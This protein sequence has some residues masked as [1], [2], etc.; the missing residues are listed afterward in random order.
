MKAVIS[1]AIWFTLALYLCTQNRLS[2]QNWDNIP[3]GSHCLLTAFFLFPQHHLVYSYRGNPL[4]GGLGGLNT[5]CFLNALAIVD[6][7][8]W[9]LSWMA[10]EPPPASSAEVSSWKG[11]RN[12]ACGKYLVIAQVKIKLQ[13][14]IQPATLTS[15]ILSRL[16][17]YSTR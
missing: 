1:Y 6:F 3:L 15:G 11:T 16:R 14:V 8:V 9:N 13:S 5:A 17:Q 12:I 4:L 10:L 7:M 2:N